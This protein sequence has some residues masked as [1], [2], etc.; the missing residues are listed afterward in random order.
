MLRVGD[1]RL[2]GGHPE[3]PGVELVVAVDQR[4]PVD[5]ARVV[6]LGRAVAPRASCSSRVSSVIDS[7]PSTRLRQNS[8]DVGG[9]GHPGGEPDDG[10]R[11]DAV[12]GQDVGEECGGP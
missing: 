7:T 2:A 9:A 4:R 1:L 6:D 8:S 5:P 10:D 3:Q 12:V 11:L